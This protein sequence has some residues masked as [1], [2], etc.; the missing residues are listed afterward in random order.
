MSSLEKNRPNVFSQ[1]EPKV[2][3]FYPAEKFLERGEI[4]VR[5]RGQG[6]PEHFPCLRDAKVTDGLCHGDAQETVGK[7]VQAFKKCYE[8]CSQAIKIKKKFVYFLL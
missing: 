1:G 2:Q 3:G 4:G 5:L 6:S 8:V 7:L